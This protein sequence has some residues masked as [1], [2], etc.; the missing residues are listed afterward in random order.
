M[1]TNEYPFSSITN[2][3]SFNV[4]RI[5]ENGLIYVNEENV[6]VRL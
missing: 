3:A 2:K 5:D 6:P 1:I 4:E